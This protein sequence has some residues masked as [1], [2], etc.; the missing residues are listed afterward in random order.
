MWPGEWA[1][2]T[3][4]SPS[5]SI[6][7]KRPWSLELIRVDQSNARGQIIERESQLFHDRHLLRKRHLLTIVSWVLVPEKRPTLFWKAYWPGRVA[8]AAFFPEVRFRNRYELNEN[9]L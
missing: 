5:R 3:A 6:S 2:S 1:A 4:L 9:V 8:G 7:P